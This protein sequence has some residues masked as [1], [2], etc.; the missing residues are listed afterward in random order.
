MN[1]IKQNRLV[2]MLLLVMA[3]FVPI[4]AWAQTDYDP[5]VTLEALDANPLGY[6]NETCTNLFDGKKTADNFSKWCCQFPTSDP[7][8]VIFKA[9]KAGVPLGYTITTGNDNERENGRNPKSWKLYGNNEGKDGS[10]TLIHEVTDDQT[11]QDKNYTSYDFTCTGTASYQ[12]FKWEI[13]ANQS[14]RTLQVSEFE[15]KLQTCSHLNSDGSSALGETI[16]TVAATCT[17]PAYTTHKCS[18]C[19]RIIEVVSDFTLVPHQLNHHE[20]IPATCTNAGSREYWQCGVCNKLF[21]DKDAATEIANVA[22]IEVPATEH[23]YDENDV[24]KNCQRQIPFVEL[25]ENTITVEAAVG[26]DFKKVSSYCLYKYKATDDGILEVTA[27]S[28]KDTYGSLCEN[29]KDI[30]PLIFND[31][32]G[33]GSD[34]K[35]AYKV[36]KD[37]IY[38]IGVREYFGEAINDE[39]KLIVNLKKQPEDLV[40][41]GTEDEAYIIRTAEHLAWFRDCVNSGCTET[42]A[43][44]ADDVQVIDMSSVCHPADDDNNVAELSWEPIGSSS[45]PYVGTFDGNGKTIKNLF[46]NS[47]TTYTGFFGSTYSGSIKNITFDN[48]KVISRYEYT[49]I[50]VGFARCTIQGIKTLDNCYVRGRR[51]TGGIVGEMYSHY[52]ISD[53]ENRATVEGESAV[54]GIVGLKDNGNSNQSFSISSCANYGSVSCTKDM[55]G[56]IAGQVVSNSVQNSANY[57][58]VKAYKTTGNI[59]GYAEECTI[60]NVLAAGDISVD[61]NSNIGLFV[62][63]ISDY[64]QATGILAYNDKATITNLVGNGSLSYPEG[65]TE[66]DIVK[67]FSTEQ[68][69]SGEVTFQL[70]GGSSEGTLFWYQKL[71]VDENPV[72]K[73]A[74]GNTVYQGTYSYCDGEASSY[75][76]SADEGKQIHKSAFTLAT[77]T[78]DADQHIYHMGCRNENCPEHKYTVDKA[79][80]LEATLN[81]DASAFTVENMT[82]DDATIY[83]SEAKFTAS[84]CIYNRTFNNDKWQAMYVPFEFNSSD[85]PE[86]YEL[87]VINNFHEYEQTDGTYNVVLEVKRATENTSIPALTP[88]LIRM[89][90]ESSEAKAETF[91]FSD[92]AFY[93]AENKSINCSSVTRYYEFTGTL[94]G[95]TGFDESK[96]FVMNRGALHMAGEQTTLKPQRWYLS[97][98]NRNASSGESLNA[99]QKSIEIREIFGGNITSIGEIFVNTEKNSSSRDGLYDLQ[100]RKLSSVP[101]QGIYIM[102]GKKYVK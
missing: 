6:D 72:L 10:W 49:G 101:A 74:D 99:Q 25:G 69:A 7:A 44:I 77:P 95:K 3:A 15:L 53:C 82:I 31:D 42:C 64:C 70:N 18:L 56:G 21:S 36:K 85:L 62:G 57:G 11:L 30:N 94:E 35:F 86:G 23:D 97:A 28:N 38:Y 12:Y 65:K 59:I 60:S 27:E 93:P 22:S 67:P 90:E 20:E 9:S 91:T 100:G 66:S 16:S 52:D 19:E 13:S 5:T 87:A 33:Y 78:F 17:K 88:C 92:V 76:N 81:E 71:G 84:S 1:R 98:T 43:K 37:A 96:D 102:N 45:I 89:K 40:G 46:V 41:K 29:P 83:D 80:K 48:A 24:C 61:H 54:G 58:H 26:N 8:Y 47:R 50:S 2:A 73:K 63:S 39:I 4:G 75:A 51:Y 55:A 32:G 68:L 34:F 14:S 79:G